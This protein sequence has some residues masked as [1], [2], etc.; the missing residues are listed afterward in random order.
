MERAI[1][2]LMVEDNP[3]D[4]ILAQ[5]AL[6]DG[7]LSLNLQVA[8]DGV[9]ALEFL[10]RKGPFAG[11]PRP[12]LILLDLNL[13]RMTGQEL[14][15]EIR[16]RSEFGQIPV[17]VLTSSAAERD[18]VAS[19]DLGASFYITKPVDFASFQEVVG[20]IDSFWFTIVRGPLPSS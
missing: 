4:V 17:V 5:E 3:A 9:E 20:M 10:Q 16:S 12:D 18:I 13:P 6:R 1:S 19:Y 8:C 11:A 14:L 15:K 7:K 2:I